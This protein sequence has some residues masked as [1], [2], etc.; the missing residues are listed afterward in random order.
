MSFVGC[1]GLVQPKVAVVP[2]GTLN[3][4]GGVTAIGFA[5][6]LAIP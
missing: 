4:A 1:I 5:D 6:E 3:E 2:A